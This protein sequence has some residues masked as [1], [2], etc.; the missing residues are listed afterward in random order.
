MTTEPDSAPAKSPNLL[1]DIAKVLEET[2]MPPELLELEITE[3]MIM[4]NVDD[5]LREVAA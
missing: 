3:S 5:R 2:G 4:H 1:D